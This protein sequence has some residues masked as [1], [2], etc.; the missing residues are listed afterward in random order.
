MS[1]VNNDSSEMTIFTQGHSVLSGQELRTQEVMK[2]SLKGQFHD[3]HYFHKRWRG[4]VTI[5]VGTSTAGKSSLIQALKKIDPGLVEDG[6]DLRY[7][8]Q[9]WKST[10]KFSPDEI[11]ILLKVLR[12]PSDIAKTL[13]SK[14]RAWKEGVTAKEQESAEEA[15]KRIHAKRELLTSEELEAPFQTMELEMIADAYAHAGRGGR[16]IFDVLR[17]DDFFKHKILS[18]FDGPMNV[19]LAF[20]PFHILSARMEK[21]NIEAFES[22]EFSNQR[23]GEF[24]LMQFSELYGPAK[25]GEA[26]IE[27]L[28]REQVVKTF[29]ENFDKGQMADPGGSSKLSPAEVLKTKERL[30]GMLLKNL[31]FKSGVDVVE[32]APKHSWTYNQVLDMSKLSPVELAKVIKK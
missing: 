17:I 27:R 2:S 8:A 18:T 6:G 26:P 20:C 22:G 31:G 7:Y 12:D 16:V 11:E 15:I 9:F 25:D 32:I 24:P 10:Q 4:E 21:R 19:V 1:L 13:F 28:T 3:S 5:L 23:I 30:R 14:E 29:D